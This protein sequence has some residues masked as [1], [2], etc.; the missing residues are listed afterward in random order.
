MGLIFNELSICC[1]VENVIDFS[2]EFHRFLNGF[3]GPESLKMSTSCTREAHF[4]TI[5]FS[6]SG[7][8]LGATIMKKGSQHGAK[9]ALKVNQKIYE[10]LDSKIAVLGAK[11]NPKMPPETLQNVTKK[12]TDLLSYFWL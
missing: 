3:W 6:D 11:M 9:M 7:T 8:I 1:S 10:I 5:A 2:I 12:R 4:Q